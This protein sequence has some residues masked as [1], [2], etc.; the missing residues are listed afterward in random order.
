MIEQD[1]EERNILA[2]EPTN[3][4]LKMFAGPAIISML[5]NSLY[6]II[7]QIFIGQAVGYLGNAATTI[8]FPIVTVVLALGT[9]FG[10]GGSAFAA[11]KLGEGRKDVAE[12][13]LNTVTAVAFIVGVVLTVGGLL[14]LEP[15]LTVFGATEKTMQYSKEFGG[16]MIAIIPMTMLIIGLSNLA[17]ADGSPRLAMRGLV[18]GVLLNVLLA[19]LF[20]FQFG[21]GVL[22]AALATACAQLLSL[23][24]F[25]W[26]F[27][28][29]SK[30]RLQLG[31]L[32]HPDM[33]MCRKPMAIG[34]SSCIL[35]S[36]ATLLQVC[37]N[38]SLLY[39]GNLSPVGGDMAI[40][41]MGIV[42]KVN[43]IVISIC[44]GIGAG[45]QPIIGF[46]RGANEPKRVK[47]TYML[48]AK[49]ASAITIFGWLCCQLIPEEILQIFGSN[50]EEFMIFAVSCMRLFLGGV[51]VAGFQIISTSYFQAT[52]QPLKAS[53]LSMLRQLILLLP[54]I[55]ILP[56]WFGLD[57]ILYAGT[58]ADL[59][60]ASIVAIF[61]I[62]EMKKLNEEIAK[63]DRSCQLKGSGV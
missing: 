7:D 6:N 49:V 22:G 39:Y 57:G 31:L 47:E 37:M 4:L 33:N 28:R 26:Y 60:A 36:G 52:G 20:I 9:L 25:I 40:S 58:I 46:N 30:M 61:M 53:V 48:A 50:G 51:F 2:Y 42:M 11:I 41:A 12:K 38:N 19:P 1:I 54:L 5:A 23:C 44:V 59:V 34:F 55:F 56:F 63:G 14:L 10:V 43:M 27:L 62:K 17:R 18:S 24:T 3:K 21:W 16:V 35:Q 32:L 13:V 29:K 8:A 15:L 45:A